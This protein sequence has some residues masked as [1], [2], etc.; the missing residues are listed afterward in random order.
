[1][2]VVLE[3]VTKF[4]SVCQY[5]LLLLGE[6]TSK[7]LVT[8][9]GQENTCFIYLTWPFPQSY[10]LIMRIFLSSQFQLL[11]ITTRCMCENSGFQ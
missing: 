3:L 7:L 2:C 10:T 4:K 8:I 5:W 11:S 6:K 1:M 9:V